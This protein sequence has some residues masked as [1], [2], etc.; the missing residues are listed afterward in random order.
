M[1]MKMTLRRSMYGSGRTLEKE[2]SSHRPQ[3]TA[4]NATA[5]PREDSFDGFEKSVIP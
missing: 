4:A 5:R 2:W 1:A 3:N